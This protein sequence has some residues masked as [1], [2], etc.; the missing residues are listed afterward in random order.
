MPIGGG[1]G[2]R[3]TDRLADLLPGTGGKPNPSP[4]TTLRLRLLLAS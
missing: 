1:G 2:R 3:P 4:V